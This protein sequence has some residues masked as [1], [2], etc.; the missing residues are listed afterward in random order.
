MHNKVVHTMSRACHRQGMHTVRFNYRGVGESEGSYG[1]YDGELGDCLAIIA[2][3]RKAQ[4]THAIYLAGFSFGSYIA[5]AAVAKD[6][7]VAG[8]I[9]IAPAITNKN[10]DD[11]ANKI[12]CPWTIIQGLSDEVIEPDA[13]LQWQR[14][15]QKPTT[16]I[17]IDTGHFFHGMLIPLRNHLEATIEQHLSQG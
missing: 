8:L 11:I 7:N 4:P 5:T 10:Y 9:T 16:L 1:N 6:Q 3:V 14:T 17:T 13:V 2:W 12:N 15:L